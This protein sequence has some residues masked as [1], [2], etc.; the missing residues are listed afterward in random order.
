M[1]KKK[2]Q[3]LWGNEGASGA[4][5]GK[6]CRSIAWLVCIAVAWVFVFAMMLVPETVE[7]T[8]TE[9]LR[10]LLYT[11]AVGLMAFGVGRK[12]GEDRK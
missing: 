12:F 7:Y 5:C 3:K 9:R 6:P 2:F 1:P 10:I 8:D 4:T 11:I